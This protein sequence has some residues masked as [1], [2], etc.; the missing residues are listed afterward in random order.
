[1]L[2]F[3]TAVQDSHLV[4]LSREF[5]ARATVLLQYTAEY[6]SGDI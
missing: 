3:D 2:Y 4:S 1:L 5:Q 6:C